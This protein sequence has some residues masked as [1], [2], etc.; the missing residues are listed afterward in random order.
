M[1]YTTT[2]FQAM[3]FDSVYAPPDLA[4]TTH[5]DEKTVGQILHMLAKNNMVE[6]VSNDRFRKNRKYKTKQRTLL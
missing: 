2:V 6:L 1:S 5:I 4:A 3:R